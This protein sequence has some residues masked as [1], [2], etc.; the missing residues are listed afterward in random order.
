[1]TF[2]APFIAPSQ[3]AT[4]TYNYI[5]RATTTGDGFP[6]GSWSSFTSGTKLVVVCLELAGYDVGTVQFNGNTMNNPV[7]DPVSGNGRGASIWTY[8]TTATSGS[9]TGTGGS[10][11]S[12]MDVFEMFNYASVTPPVTGSAYSV[13]PTSVVLNTSSGML[14]FGSGV[15]GYAAPS[16]TAD[17]GPT[18]EVRGIYLENATSHFSWVQNGAVRGPTTFTANVQSSNYNELVVAGWR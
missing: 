9:I 3:R 12:S 18:P 14:V 7:P 13:D 11:R 6:N 1:M 17:K 4:P 10:G 8:E 16:V 15:G 2:P 5:G